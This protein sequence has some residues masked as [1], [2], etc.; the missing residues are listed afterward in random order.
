MTKPFT[1]VAAMMLVEDGKLTLADPVSKYLPQLATLEVAVAKQD[2]DGKTTYT[3]VPAERPITVQDLLR[4]TSGIVY[5]N[6][7]PNQRGKRRPESFKPGAVSGIGL[8]SRG[9]GSG[10]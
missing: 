2:A 7:T 8:G 6:N 3:L 5:S 4:P 9:A 10:A 1:S